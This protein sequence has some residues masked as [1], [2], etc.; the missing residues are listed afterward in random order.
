M[1]APNAILIACLQPWPN[2]GSVI[3]N[4]LFFNSRSERLAAIVATNRS[5]TTNRIYLLTT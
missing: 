5:C 1:R 3:G 4:D 2:R